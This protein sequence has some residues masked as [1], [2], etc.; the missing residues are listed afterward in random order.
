MHCEFTYV[1]TVRLFFFIALET[2]FLIA[3]TSMS[4]EFTLLEGPELVGREAATP[5]AVEGDLVS[6]TGGW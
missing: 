5:P 4:S 2:F 1:E 6:S 3:A